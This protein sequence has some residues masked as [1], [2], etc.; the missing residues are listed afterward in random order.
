MPHT[1]GSTA[2]TTGKGVHLHNTMGSTQLATIHKLYTTVTVPYFMSS[3]LTVFQSKLLHGLTA[4]VLLGQISYRQRSDIYNYVHGYDSARKQSVSTAS[5]ESDDEESTDSR[6]NHQYF[7]V[8]ICQCT[9][10]HGYVCTR[11]W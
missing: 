11:A 9:Y 7:V 10:V 4:E 8:Y 5:H 2:C 3:D 1:S 6:Y